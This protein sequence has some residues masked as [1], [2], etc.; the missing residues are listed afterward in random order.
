MLAPA[1]LIEGVLGLEA[2]HTFAAPGCPAVTLNDRSTVA[3]A[4]LPDGTIQRDVLP[5]YKVRRI[6]GLRSRPD[7]DDTREP[8]RGGIGELV[9]PSLQRGKTVVYEGSVEALSLES[10]RAATT[11]LLAAF[12]NT[13]S[14]G[15]MTVSPPAGRGGVSWSYVARSLACDIDDVQDRGPRAVYRW[16]RN[17][18]LSVRQGDPRYYTA[19]VNVGGASGATV[20]VTNLGTAPSEPVFTLAGPIAPPV[21]IER[22]GPDP[23]QLVFA[24]SIAWLAINAG[25]HLVV[26]FGRRPRAYS[27]EAGGDFAALLTF[28]SNWWDEGV[29]GI[30]PGAQ[31][32]K[33]TGAA[34]AVAFN[35]ASW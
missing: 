22:L 19:G 18:T 10:L 20:G 9:Y 35:H 16:A 33:V 8:V 2:F 17:F 31:D 14:E 30:L 28:A 25:K 24:T 12:S 1:T 13:S 4:T 11:T 32:I 6:T 27:P 7:A 23:R 5:R 34:W 29:G 21:T 26:E 3:V 15:T